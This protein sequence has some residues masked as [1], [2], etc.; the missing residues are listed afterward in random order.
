M[1]ATDG[2][3]E[4]EAALIAAVLAAQMKDFLPEPVDS[5]AFAGSGE[6]SEQGSIPFAKNQLYRFL[7]LTNLT[8]FPRPGTC[9]AARSALSTFAATLIRLL[10]PFTVKPSAAL[11]VVA[12]QDLYVPA[13][14]MQRDWAVCNPN[15]SSVAFAVSLALTNPTASYCFPQL[16]RDKWESC[17]IRW[18]RGGHV[19][20]TIFPPDNFADCIAGVV[21]CLEQQAGDSNSHGAEILI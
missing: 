2:F 19:S 15:P 16:I 4:N 12:Q 8:N 9:C 3:C 11:F 13:E 14:S 21:D 6:T 7:Q 10:A 17:K 5:S 1:A 18:I 20:G